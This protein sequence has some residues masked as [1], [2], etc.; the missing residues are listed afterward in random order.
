MQRFLVEPVQQFAGANTRIKKPTEIAFFSYDSEHK[1]KPLD[2]ESLRYYYPPFFNVPGHQENRFPVELSKG[3]DSFRQRDDSGDEHLDGLLDTLVESEKRNGKK[4]E[5][6]FVTWRAPYEMEDGFEMN[7][8]CFQGTIYIEE[9]HAYKAASRESQKARFSRNRGPPQDM[10]MFWGYKFETLSLLNKPWGETT[11]EE[12]EGREDEVVDNYAQ[13][14]SICRTEI[15]GASM[16]IGGEVD[17]VLGY[18]PDDP[19]APARWV[20]L[21]TSKQPEHERDRWVLDKKLLKFWAQSFLLKFVPRQIHLSGI[22]LT[23]CSVPKI[24]I[25]FRSRDGK[26]LNIEEMNTQQIPSRIQQQG[27]YKWNGNICINFTGQF[28]DFLKHTIVGEGVWRIRREAKSTA[29]EVFRVEEQGT[30][31]I[32]TQNFIDH[33]KR[34]LAGEVKD[35]GLV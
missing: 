28:L 16:V 3:Y 20:E 18:K 5:V 11:R 32:L 1:L 27:T 9:N 4:T 14:C 12:I 13:Y 17:G 30:G 8:T 24:I 15:G 7:A 23:D 19:Q 2:N 29:I 31:N 35:G 21:K 22:W 6:D 26:L 33:R 25:G 10:A 34:L